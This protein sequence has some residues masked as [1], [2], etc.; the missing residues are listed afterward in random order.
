MRMTVF[1][2]KYLALIGILVGFSFNS[3]A[4]NGYVKEN[5]FETAKF[6]ILSKPAPNKV[7]LLLVTPCAT[8]SQVNLKYSIGTLIMKNGQHD[9]KHSLGFYAGKTVG[10]S[11]LPDTRIVTKIIAP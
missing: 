11:Y 2:I 6:K 9:T 10:I 7:G 8:C 4:K 3:F 5:T 1:R